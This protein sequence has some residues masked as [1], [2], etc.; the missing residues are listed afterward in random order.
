MPECTECSAPAHARYSWG[1]H[2]I[3][4][5]SELLCEQCGLIVRGFMGPY[6]VH[7]YGFLNIDSVES[8][9]NVAN[10]K[11]P[12]IGNLEDQPYAPLDQR[13]GQHGEEQDLQAQ[14]E[15]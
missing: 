1:Y 2:G 9:G 4:P 14:V 8:I 11:F 13:Q 7:A 12:I 5:R 6:I 3:Q 15:R 10:E